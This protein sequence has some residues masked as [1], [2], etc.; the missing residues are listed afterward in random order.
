MKT[1]N[2]GIQYFYIKKIYNIPYSRKFLEGE[3]FG[4]FGKNLLFLKIYFRI[5]FVL[6]FRDGS[7]EVPHAEAM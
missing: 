5:F 6:V 7:L 2:I 1:I 3:I 4:N